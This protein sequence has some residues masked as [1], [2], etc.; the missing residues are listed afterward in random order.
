MVLIPGKSGDASSS[1]A[2]VQ[3][4]NHQILCCAFNANGTVFVTGSSDTFARV[5][6]LPS[7]VNFLSNYGKLPFF[8]K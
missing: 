1:A 4:T 2:Q 7:L 8:I 3:P 5:C 6:F